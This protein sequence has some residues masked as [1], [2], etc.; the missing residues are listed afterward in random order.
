MSQI[1]QKNDPC[2][3]VKYNGKEQR[4]FDSD[5]GII[6]CHT[7]AEKKYQTLALLSKEKNDQPLALNYKFIG[8][9]EKQKKE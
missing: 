3:K 7:D 1:N 8:Q 4:K 5:M 6:V 9:L 2:Q